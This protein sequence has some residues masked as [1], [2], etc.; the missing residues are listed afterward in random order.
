MIPAKIREIEKILPLAWLRE[1]LPA[2]VTRMLF[3][4]NFPD[5]LQ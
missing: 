5:F 2:S 1:E 3:T 4:P